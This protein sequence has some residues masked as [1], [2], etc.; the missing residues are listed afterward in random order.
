M[1]AFVFTGQGAQRVGMGEDLYR[2]FQAA[3][4]IF[5]TADRVMNWTPSVT[6]LCLIGPEEELIL[7]QNAQPA[8]LT[9][10]I[11]TLRAIERD[12]RL[13][14]DVVA[15]HSL[16]E[17]AALV[18]AGVLAFEDAVQI[19]HLRGKFMQAAVKKG[20]GSMAAI[21][22]SSPD[23]VEK[24]CQDAAEGQILV[25]ANFNS[26]K[27]IVISGHKEAIGRAIGLGKERGVTARELRV[28]APFHCPLMEPA[29][30]QLAAALEQITF[31]DAKIPVIT[32]VEA[33][34]TQDGAKLRELLVAQVTA[35]VR[36]T[37]SV[38]KMV[39]MG[40]REFAEL[41]PAPVLTNLIKATTTDARATLYDSAEAILAA[42]WTHETDRRT[43]KETGRIVWADGMEWDPEAPGAFGF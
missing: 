22:N 29:A 40:V 31:Q 8:M 25:P 14:P 36:W 35:P 17:Y 21:S 18:A 13:K 11:A 1:L 42:D 38:N 20:K 3:R 33:E 6:N 7:T 39:E 28:S 16:G 12:T 34:P 4:D 37:E 30:N 2:N 10:G 15:G 24:L 19:V 23:A 26:P 32:N 27:Q 43:H 9:V 41:G 5:E